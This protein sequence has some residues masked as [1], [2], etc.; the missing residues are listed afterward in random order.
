VK[1]LCRCVCGGEKETTSGNLQSG[2]TTSCG[3][4]RRVDLTGQV[5]GRLTAVKRVDGRK[6]L[7]RCVCG[8]AK[9]I[10]TGNLKSGHVS[11]C[12]CVLKDQ[13][14]AIRDEFVGKIFD[15]L[16]PFDFTGGRVVCR[17][18]CGGVAKV[19]PLNLR[20]HTVKSCGCKRNEL[21]GASFRTHGQSSKYGGKT[22]EYSAWS[23]MKQRCLDP[24]C[25]I[26]E[27]YGKRGITIYATWISSFESFFE[28]MGPRPSAHHSIDRID[29]DGN[30]EPGN[31]RWATSKQQTRNTRRSKLNETD[32]KFIHHWLELG[33]LQKDIATA[34]VVHKTHIA[35]INRGHK[36]A[37]DV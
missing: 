23:H 29:N 18:V 28:Y 21:I 1:W 6:W 37:A 22:P 12:G 32:L 27:N 16:T 19:T 26:Y 34:F 15:Y 25:D 10:T 17:C 30:Y 35:N 24:E 11:S 13:Q 5:F 8:G 20:S 14:N 2:N 33:Y 7:R 3:C 4:V 31:V 9:E 36:W